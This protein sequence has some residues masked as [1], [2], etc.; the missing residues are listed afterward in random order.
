LPSCA[1][2]RDFA[3]FEM[4]SEGHPL[5]RY[6]QDPDALP[7]CAIHRTDTTLSESSEAAVYLKVVGEEGFE[8][9]GLP[10]PTHEPL[11]HRRF[12]SDIPR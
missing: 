9:G 1:I 11:A 6:S 8:R 7:S 3:F 5:V 12:I 2:H 10:Y 4:L